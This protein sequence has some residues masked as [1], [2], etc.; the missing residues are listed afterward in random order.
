MKNC[1]G[2]SCRLVLVCRSKCEYVFY[3]R[4]VLLL[5]ICPKWMINWIG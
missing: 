3:N 1:V 2:L 5:L 4:N